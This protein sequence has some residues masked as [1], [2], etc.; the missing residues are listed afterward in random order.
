MAVELPPNVPARVRRF[1]WVLCRYDIGFRLVQDPENPRV[2]LM[3][4]TELPGGAELPEGCA[5][6]ITYRLHPRR[7][8]SS[9]VSLVL[10]GEPVEV[11]DLSSALLK[12][13]QH[14]PKSGGMSAVTGSSG[15]ARSNAV[16]TRRQSVIRV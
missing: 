9:D 3:S 11:D 13:M 15:S 4:L 6:A 7:K 8:T 2:W 12:M 14:K 16:E 1:I 10:D 5:L